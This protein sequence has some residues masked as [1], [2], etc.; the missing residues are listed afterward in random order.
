MCLIKPL[1]SI[2]CGSNAAGIKGTIYH[3]PADEFASW[4]AFLSTTGA[5]DTVKLTGNFSLVTTSGFGYFRSFPCLLEKGSVKYNAVGGLGSKSVEALAVYAIAGMDA[6]Q[7][8]H[9]YQILNIPGVWLFPDKNSSVHV[10]G[11]NDDPAY[12]QD[13]AGDTG[14]AATDERIIT[15]TV[16]AIQ[17]RPVLYTGTINTTP[18]T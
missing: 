5:G 12:I 13:A 11:K 6:A 7:L 16:R 18:A 15:L 9:F 8:E 1:T 2:P 17:P 10:I 14:T 3:I 4:P